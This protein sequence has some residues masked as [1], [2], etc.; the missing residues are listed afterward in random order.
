MNDTLIQKIQSSQRCIE[1]AREIYHKEL[2]NFLWKG[3][4]NFS[5]FRVC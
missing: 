3:L 2:F 5:I 4:D 1:R